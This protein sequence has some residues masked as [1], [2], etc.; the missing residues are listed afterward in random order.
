MRTTL[1]ATRLF[2]IMRIQHILCC[3]IL[4]LVSSTIATAQQASDYQ[5]KAENSTN[6]LI[7]N[8]DT[9]KQLD[10]V[11]KDAKRSIRL[12]L[13]LVLNSA[14]LLLFIFFLV[15]QSKLRR[16]LETEKLRNRLSRDL[17]DDIGSTLS[18]INILSRTAQSTL[19]ITGNEKARLSLEKINERSQRLLDNMSDIIWNI[20]PGNDTIEEVM[21]R[22]REYATTLLEAKDIN[23]HFDFPKEKMDCKLTIH[24]KSNLYLIFKE[25][26]NNLAK[27]SACTEATLT[28]NFSEKH[29]YLAIQDNGKGFDERTLTHNGGLQNIRARAEEMNGSVEIHS[30]LNT[31]TKISLTAPKFC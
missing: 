20:K 10:F 22:M 25:A 16:L 2:F 4:L 14:V 31:G 3:S 27:Y 17:H 30:L 19:A 9:A 24:V 11:R 28:L 12:M 1:Y 29:L 15:R 18:S 13:I 6:K 21:S 7:Q 26:V 23:Y 5:Q 8:N